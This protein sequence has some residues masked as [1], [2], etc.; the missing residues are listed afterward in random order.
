MLCRN[1]SESEH[2][3]GNRL[4]SIFKEN[5]LIYRVNLYLL[6]VL[7][8]SLTGWTVWSLNPCG[9]RGLPHSFLWALGP[10]KISVKMVP[11]LFPKV[12]VPGVW[13]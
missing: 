13:H 12:K 11:G 3:E 1:S 4:N 6:V 9:W 5:I 10:T 7:T 8:H 2:A